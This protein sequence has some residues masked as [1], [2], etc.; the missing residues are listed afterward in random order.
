MI[1]SPPEQLVAVAQ[2]LVPEAAI[3]LRGADGI[4]GFEASEGNAGLDR[5]LA[6]FLGG[7]NV[8][9]AGRGGAGAVHRTGLSGTA[10][11]G[12]G[13]PQ[14]TIPD[15]ADQRATATGPADRI[16][17]SKESRNRE[18]DRKTPDRRSGHDDGRRG[19]D[20]GAGR[21]LAL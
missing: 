16:H 6:G 8:N 17:R 13:S 9:L 7:R 21:I 5:E 1:D 3:E 20:L 4:G 18:R 11:K 14:R 12:F 15:P 2:D 19:I 10:A